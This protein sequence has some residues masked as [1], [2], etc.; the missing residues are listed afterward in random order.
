VAEGT[1]STSCDARGFRHARDADGQALVV[2]NG[3]LR[4]RPVT[5]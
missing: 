3:T 1:R 2:R 5:P 4:P